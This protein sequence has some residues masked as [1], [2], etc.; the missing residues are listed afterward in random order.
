MS[1]AE[2]NRKHA[3]ATCLAEKPIRFRELPVKLLLPVLEGWLSDSVCRTAEKS[4]GAAQHAEPDAGPD[5]LHSHLCLF[6]SFAWHELYPR[7][8]V[9]SRMSWMTTEQTNGVKPR[10]DCTDSSL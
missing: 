5:H 8:T 3:M 7:S 4:F 2:L 10:S 1:A 9:T 6:T